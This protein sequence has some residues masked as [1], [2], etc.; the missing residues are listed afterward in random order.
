MK[1]SGSLPAE[2]ARDGLG[3]D[4]AYDA[5]DFVGDLQAA[6]RASRTSQ[7]KHQPRTGAA[8]CPSAG[9]G[10]VRLRRQPQGAQAD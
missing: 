6:G 5:Q 10:Q 8:R 9:R 2:G 3:A 7:A 4:Q 1:R